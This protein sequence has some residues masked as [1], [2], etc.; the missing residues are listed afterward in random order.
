MKIYISG[1]IS[2]DPFYEQSFS[3]A[4]EYLTYLGYEVTNP[5]NIPTKDFCGPDRDIKRWHYFMRESIILL[6]GCDQIYMLEGYENSRGAN[7]EHSIALELAM[8]RMYETEDI[9]RV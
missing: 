9:D 3:K 4:E 7:L 6:M 2:H 5:V 1:P 8:P